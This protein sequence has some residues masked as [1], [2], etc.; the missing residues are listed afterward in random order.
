MV[1]FTLA[2]QRHPSALSGI[3]VLFSLL[4]AS[5]V[6][7]S[8]CHGGA[9]E[10]RGPA[11]DAANAAWLL[12][13]LSRDPTMARA[14][15]MPRSRTSGESTFDQIKTLSGSMGVQ[16]DLLFLKYSDLCALHRPS[17][18]LLR[19]GPQ[20]AGYFAVVLQAIPGQVIT[21]NAG[22]LTVGVFSEDEFRL[23]W[24]G[25]VL[26][27]QAGGWIPY[28]LAVP[29]FVLGIAVPLVI[30]RPLIDRWRFG[31]PGAGLLTSPLRRGES[32]ATG[33][34]VNSR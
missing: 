33:Q 25:H 2:R 29:L 16:A 8:R 18:V 19:H 15:P 30:R 24:T 10:L 34:P 17:V 14:I 4:I 28:G 11:R 9:P 22:W 27:P 31:L 3:N 12:A 23:R 7:P 13:S 20:A 32:P 6:P 5:C 1:I 26:V 21:I